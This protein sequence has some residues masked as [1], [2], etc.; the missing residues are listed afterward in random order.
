MKYLMFI[1]HAED[2]SVQPP[3]AL[4]EA[5]GEF[6]NRM[7]ANGTLKETGGLKPTSA[8]YRIR[9]SGGKLRVIDGPFTES[10]EIIGGY[11]LVE[12]KSKEEADAVAREF[13]ELHRLHWPE[14]ECESEIRP[15]EDM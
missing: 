15:V 4:M 10:K 7:L 3:P 1:K 14:F 9:S 8:G 5:M 12:T 13:M 2:Q 6:V 11:A